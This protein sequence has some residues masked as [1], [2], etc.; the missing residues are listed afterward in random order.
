[1]I[2]IYDVHKNCPIFKA[3]HPLSIYVRNPSTQPPDLG[4]Q[5]SNE[6]FPPFP[7]DNQSN[8]RKHDPS[9][10]IICY[11]QSA[12]SFFFKLGFTPCKAE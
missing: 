5:I 1:M 4:Y 9:M 11:Q 8:K 10:T 3:P 7:N 2:H 6:S 12:L